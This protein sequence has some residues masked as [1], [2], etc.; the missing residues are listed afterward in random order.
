MYFE[1]LV[2]VILPPFHT[3]C[4]EIRYLHTSYVGDG[5]H[6]QQIS[7]QKCILKL[8]EV[9]IYPLICLTET[10]EALH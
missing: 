6:N 9:G 7:V 4:E 5:E 8:R 10:A 1:T 2:A 3:G